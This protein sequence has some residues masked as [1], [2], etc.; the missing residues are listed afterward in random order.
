MID[1][2]KLSDAVRAI[3]PQ[4]APDPIF[5]TEDHPSQPL[6]I[7]RVTF[8]KGK[9]TVSVPCGFHGRENDA[10]LAQYAKNI[11]AAYEAQK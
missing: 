4:G 2:D 5:A 8:G 11:I 9:G 1:H 7:L 10:D 3:L 6:P